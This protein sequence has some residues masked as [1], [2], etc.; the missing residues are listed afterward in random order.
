MR[1]LIVLKR[2]FERKPMGDE[3][4]PLEKLAVYRPQFL[5]PPAPRRK[6]IQKGNQHDNGK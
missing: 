5:N 1:L 6:T 4:L 3:W 2:L